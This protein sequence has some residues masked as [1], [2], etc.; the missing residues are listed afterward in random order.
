MKLTSESKILLGILSATVGIIALAVVVM[1]QPAKPIDRQTLLPADSTTRG[2]ASASAYLVEF[3]DFQCPACKAVKPVVDQ[4]VKTYGDR[5]VFSYR[6]FPLPQHTYAQKA[7]IAAEAA[8]RQGKF[9]EMYDL[10]FANSESL[11][12]D[13]ITG[14][15]DQLGLDKKQFT[16]DIT[17]LAITGRVNRDRDYGTTI[18]IN[19]TPTF[20]LNGVKLNLTSWN[21]LKTEVEK[22]LQ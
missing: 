1:S 6:H 12:D 4:I 14:F 10:L 15:A 8:G 16:A 9:W 2:N 21:N 18:G 17:D 3:S 5:L 19:A 7:A 22:V 11:S 20:Y 13:M